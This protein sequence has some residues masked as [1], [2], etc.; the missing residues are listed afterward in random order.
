V[1]ID[2][3]LS[4]RQILDLASKF[5]AFTG[6]QLVTY[7]IPSSPATI[8]GQ[9]VQLVLSG[10]PQPVLNLFRGVPPNPNDPKNTL[11]Q[12]HNGTPESG[13]AQ[14]VGDDLRSRGF[15]I[16]DGYTADFGRFD[17]AE[18]VVQYSPGAQAR[19]ALVASYL[20]GPFK[21]VEA[22]LFGAD[23]D[24]VVGADWQGVAEEPKAAET[25]AGSSPAPTAPTTAPTTTAPPPLPPPSTVPVE[26]AIY[27]P[28]GC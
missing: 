7:E 26:R 10:P 4:V 13:K 23:V 24:V 12:V 16:P 20:K 18:T 6:D 9:E 17:V 5:K 21:L 1:T 25:P 15:N 11:V 22:I 3:R 19:G 14:A 27:V 28:S 8:Q 2:E